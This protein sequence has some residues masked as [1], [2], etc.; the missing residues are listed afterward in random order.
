MTN[1]KGISSEEDLKT[2][3]LSF[4]RWIA[5][6][7]MFMFQSSNFLHPVP[8]EVSLLGTWMYFGQ[9][10]RVLYKEEG[11]LFAFAVPLFNLLRLSLLFP[12]SDF[13]SIRSTWLFYWKMKETC[14]IISHNVISVWLRGIISKNP[15]IMSTLNPEGPNKSP[16][17]NNYKSTSGSHSTKLYLVSLSSF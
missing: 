12:C 1:T 13:L 9:I 3:T 17:R 10:C 2:V 8:R 14:I 11:V 5:Q 4:S 6:S 15:N 16:K 7:L